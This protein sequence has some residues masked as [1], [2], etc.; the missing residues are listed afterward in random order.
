MREASAPSTRASDLLRGDLGHH[1]LEEAAHDHALRLLGRQAA[2]L[3]VEA[4][5]R[6]DG[7]RGR[8]VAA[9]QD[10][11]GL[12]LEHR[13]RL[14]AGLRRQQQVA[15]LLVAAGALRLVANAGHAIEGGARLVVQ[16][17]QVE[18]VRG[19]V[20]GD[21]VLDAVDVDVLR[22]AGGQQA[23]HARRAALAGHAHFDAQLGD[24]RADLGVQR[25]H[26]GVLA[27]LDALR[28]EIPGGVPQALQAGVAH[29]RALTRHHVGDAAVPGGDPVVRA[30]LLQQRHAASLLGHHQA[31]REVRPPPRRDQCVATSGLVDRHARAARTG[32]CRPT[33]G[34]GRAPRSA[35]V[36]PASGHGPGGAAPAPAARGRH[37][38][39]RRRR[40]RPRP[41][42]PAGHGS[43]AAPRRH[44]PPPRAAHPARCGATPPPGRWAAASRPG[45]APSPRAGRAAS[46][47]PL[48]RRRPSSPKPPSASRPP[49]PSG[50]GSAGSSRPR[51]PSA[52]P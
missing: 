19:G 28:A 29:A 37:R 27:D 18:Q 38:P 23:Q 21:Q 51:T 31:D 32:R 41:G 50:A 42:A 2:R 6:I 25:R 12:D 1:L 5:G 17:R 36:S 4:L 11:V 33:S 10:V 24:R 3:G 47:P 26:L 14:R 34:P 15:A 8:A 30:D 13:D 40:R 52:A 44:R 7:P 20:A 16:G 9:A 43:C 39:G 48:A 35:R 49:L 22:A 46:R 45:G